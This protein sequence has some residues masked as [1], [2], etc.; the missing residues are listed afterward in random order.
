MTKQMLD[1]AKEIRELIKQYPVDSPEV[2]CAIDRLVENSHSDTMSLHIVHNVIEMYHSIGEL[3]ENLYNNDGY[4]TPETWTT[5]LEGL[6]QLSSQVL[7]MKTLLETQ[8]K[9]A[10]Q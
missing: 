8:P 7:E 1:S 5:I 4:T 2:K 3:L 10:R 9:E 6:I